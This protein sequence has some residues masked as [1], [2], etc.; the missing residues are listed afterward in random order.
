MLLTFSLL[1][2]IRFLGTVDTLMFFKSTKLP[3]MRRAFSRLAKN[4]LLA[5]YV[6]HWNASVFWFISSRL[7]DEHRF[8]NQR[9]LDSNNVPTSFVARFI[10]NYVDGQ[11]ALF[12]LLR[13]VELVGEAGYQAG[14]MLIAAVIY[15]SIFGNLVSIVRSLDDQAA[16][17]KAVKSRNFKKAFLRQYLIN[18]KFPATL[19]RRI[20]DQE[21]FDFIHKKG[22]DTDS[23]FSS[24]PKTL[25][26]EIFTHLYWE[27]VSKV[28]L[29]S[30]ADDTFKLALTERITAITVQA[31]FYICKAG[32]A[33]QEMYFIR[34]GGVHVMPGDES[35]VFVTLQA[36]SFFGEIALMEDS[37]RTA[38][39]KTASETQ[40]CVLH[41]NDFLDIM[42]A[43]P[44][45]AELIYK[46]VKDTK[47]A[48]AKRKLLEEAERQRKENEEAER[49]A[50][51][52]ADARSRHFLHSVRGLPSSG[53]SR[54]DMS[55]LPLSSARK[56]LSNRSMMSSFRSIAES[57]TRGGGSN[58]HNTSGAIPHVPSPPPPVHPYGLGG[59]ASPSGSTTPT[60][61]PMTSRRKNGSTDGPLVQ[62]SAFDNG[63]EA[64]P[65]SGPP[66]PPSVSH[67]PASPAPHLQ[68]MHRVRNSPIL[69]ND[70]GED[71]K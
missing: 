51:S 12:F 23:L 60:S 5:I 1:R 9:L 56:I 66:A 10:M 18:N 21:E 61:G 36:G 44:T 14:E 2:L 45:V 40:L 25:R 39:C 4:L 57:L 70:T 47:E 7:S 52:Q 13:E 28:P 22:M 26:Q 27:L 71:G 65:R 46:H 69:E 67:Q 54:R 33:G 16:F 48:D 59:A 32:D 34:S 68:S 31:G 49:K 15:G 8:I 19:Q 24:L 62:K 38:T 11:K 58:G 37:K 64:I 6:S 53:G 42:K 55:P 30:K 17:D 43:F 29:F 50:R 3:F 20:L 35:K 41:K 63:H